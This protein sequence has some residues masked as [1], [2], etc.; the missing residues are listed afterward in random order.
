MD[1][2]SQFSVGPGAN[3]TSVV[4]WQAEFSALSVNEDQAENQ[5]AR[6]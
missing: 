1:Y 5:I 3:E 4:V 2:T 6:L